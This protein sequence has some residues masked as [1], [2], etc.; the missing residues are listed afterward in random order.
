MKQW[1]YF[2]KRLGEVLVHINLRSLSLPGWY[3]HVV[4]GVL[5]RVRELVCS[6]ELERCSG[7]SLAAGK[8]H[9][10]LT[11]FGRSEGQDRNSSPQGWVLDSYLKTSVVSKPRQRGGPWPENGPKFS[12]GI[13]KNEVTPHFKSTNY[14]S[15]FFLFHSRVSGYW[16]CRPLRLSVSQRTSKRHVLA[17]SV[18][19]ALWHAEHESVNMRTDSCYVILTTLGPNSFNKEESTMST[20]K[21]ACQ[22][23]TGTNFSRNVLLCF[24]QPVTY[25]LWSVFIHSFIC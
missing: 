13:R 12:R 4:E 3:L 8:G 1:R 18:E 14:R 5:R 22:S 9:T 2:K 6:T 21:E 17:G 7:G 10:C 20:M 23:G 19:C 24:P 25:Q 11:A 16:L 15:T